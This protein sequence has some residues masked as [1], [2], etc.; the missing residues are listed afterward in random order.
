MVTV[1]LQASGGWLPLQCRH[2]MLQAGR[3]AGSGVRSSR[4]G[5]GGEEEVVVEEVILVLARK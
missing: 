4:G 5:G 2:V 1:A 3:Q